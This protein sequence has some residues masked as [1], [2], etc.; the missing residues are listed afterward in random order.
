MPLPQDETLPKGEQGG[1]ST[2]KTV[3]GADTEELISK[4]QQLGGQSAEDEEEDEDDNEEAEAEEKEGVTVEGGDGN[5][6]KKKKKKKKKGK[7]SKA[8]DKLK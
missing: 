4:I 6:D 8:I 2:S 1:P 5:A 3:D 7:T